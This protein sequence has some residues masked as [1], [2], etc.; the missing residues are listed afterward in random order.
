[1][2]TVRLDEDLDKQLERLAKDT[3]RNKAYFVREAVKKYL[4][5]RAD[6]LLALK[7]LEDAGPTVSLEE[8]ESATFGRRE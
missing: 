3:G 7:R 8:V 1:M 5:D 6:Y 2:L 4:E